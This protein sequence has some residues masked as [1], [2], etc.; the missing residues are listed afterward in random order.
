MPSS[1]LAM[2]CKKYVPS[3]GASDRTGKQ[4]QSRAVI[5]ALLLKRESITMIKSESFQVWAKRRATDLS[6][7]V[8]CVDMPG[9][10]ESISY[11][12]PA[13]F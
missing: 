8:H 9:I 6:K 4:C 11:Q 3:C 1:V 10:P 12:I 7:F 2:G 13:L 5:L